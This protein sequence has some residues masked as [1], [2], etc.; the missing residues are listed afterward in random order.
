[1]GITWR[2][3]VRTMLLSSERLVS[4]LEPER[5]HSSFDSTTMF[6][7]CGTLDE[8]LHALRNARMTPLRVPQYQIRR[9][10]LPEVFCAP[11]GWCLSCDATR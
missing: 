1:M 9:P 8:I 4:H 10:C 6:D 5:S 7:A 2:M 3:N 11:S